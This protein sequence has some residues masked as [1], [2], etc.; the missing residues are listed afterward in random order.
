MSRRVFCVCFC[1]E[2]SIMSV[3]PKNLAM[4]V[5]RLANFNRQTIR[6]R[7]MSNDE[8]PSGGTLTF[9]LPTNSTIDLK[10]MQFISE[11]HCTGKLRTSPSDS[12]LPYPYMQTDGNPFPPGWSGKRIAIVPP[13]NSQSLI[14]RLDVNCNGQS[15]N[16]A[17]NEYHSIYNI[18][19]QHNAYQPMIGQKGN[20]ATLTR[21]SFED[22]IEYDMMVGR[23]GE[24][25]YVNKLDM[26]THTYPVDPSNAD[27]FKPGYSKIAKKGVDWIADVES[28]GDKSVAWYT[29]D[30]IGL[31]RPGYN[32]RLHLTPHDRPDGSLHEC[33]FSNFHKNAD[34]CIVPVA[35]NDAGQCIRSLAPDRDVQ[36]GYPAG[37][38]QFPT[39]VTEWRGLTG[40]FGRNAGRM[41]DNAQPSTNQ[42]NVSSITHGDL[43]GRDVVRLPTFNADVAPSALA[44]KDE[45]I[46]K[47]LDR[48]TSRRIVMEGFLGLLSGKYCRFLDTAVTG[49]VEV[50]M[51]LAP[52]G[53]L[54][55]NK[56][57][58][59]DDVVD[60]NYKLS[61][62]YMVL[63]TISF[64]DD[65]YR[66]I[67]A[68][69]LIQGGLITI[70]YDNFFNY[71]YPIVSHS[72]FVSF[73][74]ATQSLDYLIATVRDIEALATYKPKPMDTLNSRMFTFE[75]FVGMPDSS[76]EDNL[77]GV[78]AGGFQFLVN[79]MHYPTWSANIDEIEM[80]TKSAWDQ[81]ADIKET[82]GSVYNKAHFRGKTFAH[83]VCLKHHSEGEKIISGLDTRGA[84]SMMQWMVS[85]LNRPTTAAQRAAEKL[86]PG[87]MAQPGEGAKN[88]SIFACCTSTIEFSA[89]QNATIVF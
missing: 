74:A 47:I 22:V 70:P 34:D 51:K 54:M 57:R 24:Y 69:R 83:V 9:K 41:F 79:N 27:D 13:L 73:T 80:L 60:C 18:I 77:L 46:D 50:R 48:Y 89:G 78:N 67:L 30:R 39:D 84:S 10:N 82:C 16:G 12:A 64:T 52:P 21:D 42:Y 29:K 26:A 5:Q 61:N 68:R 87:K 88:C 62:M 85:G 63:D 49:P 86:L 15:T 66:Q 32:Q 40:V 2:I 33:Q 6:I 53:V 19:Y 11:I 8:C 55:C 14:E 3:L 28:A 76:Y 37:D 45:D 23:N 31:F 4:I 71:T 36:L 1:N 44:K 25:D 7:P 75:S 43:A 59:P 20:H 65:F 58:D 81:A 17:N 38:D 35:A 72:H 56:Y